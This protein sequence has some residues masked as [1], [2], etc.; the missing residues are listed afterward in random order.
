MSVIEIGK[1]DLVTVNPTLAKQWNYEKNGTLTPSMVGGYSNI[2]VWWVCEKGHE[3]E[4]T[5]CT[6]NNGTGCPVCSNK[7]II[8]GYNDL[9]TTNPELVKK[10]DFEKNQIKPTEVTF[11]STKKVWW[12][13]E[14]GHNYLNTVSK[15]TYRGDG[16]P[17]CSNR[18]VLAGYNDLKTVR[19]DLEKEW[20]YEKNIEV[21]PTEV[22]EFSN[23]DVWWKCKLGHEYVAKICDRSHGNGCPI[24]SNHKVLAGFN[25][26]ATTHPQ[27]LAEWDYEKNE[28]K[29]TEITYGSTEKVWWKCGKGHSWQGTVNGR[30]YNNS[31]CPICSN[32]MLLEGY[33]DLATL[34]PELLSMWN[35]PKNTLKPTE[36]MPFSN[37]KVWWICEK[38][39]EWEAEVQN[40]SNGRRCPYCANKKLLP[41][42][43]DLATTRP[44]L[45]KEW[46]YKRN[47]NVKP[48]DIFA[49]TPKRFWWICPKGHEYDAKTNNRNSGFDCPYCANKKILPGYNDFASEYPELLSEWDYDKNEIKPTEIPSGSEKKVWWKCKEGH[50]WQAVLN[51]RPR[52]NG[53]PYCSGLMPIKGVNDL[54]TVNPEIMKSWNYEKNGDLDPSDFTPVSGK[55]VWWKGECGHEWESLISNRVK[56]RGCPYCAGKKALAGFNDLMSQMPEVASEWNYERNIGKKPEDFTIH[57]NKKVWWKCKKDHEWQATITSRSSGTGCPI[58]SNHM[59]VKG[60]NDLATTDPELASEWNYERN[61]DLLPDGFVH[62]SA[63]KVWWKCKKGHEWESTIANRNYGFGCPYCYVSHLEKHT[64]KWLNRNNVSYK[65]QIKYDNLTGYGGGKLSY[66]FGI[67]KEDKIVCLIEC[68]GKQHYKVSTLFGGE[69]QFAKQQLHDELKK[70]YADKIGIPLIEIPYTCRNYKEVR[71]FFENTLARFI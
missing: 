25:D 38:G 20:N 17:Y 34:K 43:N 5:V 19:P 2:K 28:I 49:G 57:S 33:N 64:E 30:T 22:R 55:R 6:R 50:E 24:C 1:N 66:D 59:L 14:K 9:A 60:V 40:I 54:A 23:L 47:G 21:E 41:G 7:K 12:K 31:G 71:I 29:P 37:T 68:Q 32:Q 53:C 26:I 35:Y 58:C 61:G 11:G 44:D 67:L 69:E 18:R 10:W 3:W 8:V 39:H 70:D 65:R 13:C 46:N 56:G 45:A 36:V 62:G 42:F 52:G 48:S 51:S 15:M 27:L 16:C 63:Q 4:A